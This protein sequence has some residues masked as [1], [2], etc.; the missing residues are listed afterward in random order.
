MKILFTAVLFLTSASAWAQGTT[1]GKV[2]FPFTPDLKLLKE[3]LKLSDAQA[4]AI[5]A[6]YTAYQEYLSSKQSEILQLR[7]EIAL[8]TAKETLDP[9]ELGTRYVEIETACRD[10]QSEAKAYQKKNTDGLTAVQKN[11]LAALQTALSLLPVISQAQSVNVM[12]GSTL[13]TSSSSRLVTS[14]T[15]LSTLGGCSS[16][17]LVPSTVVRGGDF[18]PLP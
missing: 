15:S 17:A 5:T 11:K 7:L 10:I 3:Y 4:D 1:A 9:M 14:S 18:M 2:F 8:Q 6:N 16:S 13:L 12:A